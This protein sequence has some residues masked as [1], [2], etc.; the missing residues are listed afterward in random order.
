MGNFYSVERNTQ[1][2]IS[3]LKEHNIKKIILS[4]GATNVCFVGSVMND[5][6]FELYSQHFLF[7]DWV[8]C[9]GS[10]ILHPY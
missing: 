5:S 4:P 10:N 1:M 8:I 6:F 3:L 9:F 7:R 2:L